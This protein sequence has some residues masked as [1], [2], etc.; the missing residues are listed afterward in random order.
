MTSKLHAVCDSAGRPLRLH[1]TAGQVSDY[2]GAG[3]LLDTLPAA[4]LMIADR[5]YD[6]DWLRTA[7]HTAGIEACIPPKRNRVKPVYFNRSLYKTRYKIENMFA[8][9]KDWRRIATRYDR[10]ASSFMAAIKIA[11]IVIFRINQ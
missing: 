3:V 1:L 10:C 7:L 6:A 5:G 2:R 9:L 4:D 8:K 11:V